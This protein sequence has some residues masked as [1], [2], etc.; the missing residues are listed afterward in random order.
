M[1]WPAEI[2]D[3]KARGARKCVVKIIETGESHCATKAEVE[4]WLPNIDSPLPDVLALPAPGF[5]S[6]SP[7]ASLLGVCSC[8]ACCIIDS[9]FKLK[10]KCAG[11]RFFIR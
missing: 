7:L 1:F 10:T 3:I 9:K 11:V 6:L 2:I 5:V 4:S 8:D